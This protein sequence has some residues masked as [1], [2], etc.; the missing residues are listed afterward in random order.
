MTLGYIAKEKGCSISTIQRLF[1]SYLDNPSIPQI[2]TNNNCHLLIDGTYSS[3][4]CQLNYFDNDLKYLQYFDMV[5]HETYLD[6]RMGL[7]ALKK[8]GL[9]IVSITCDGHKGLLNAIYD[10]FP[11]IVV[12][13]CVVHIVRMSI[14]YLRQKP[15]YFA[16]I[17]LKKIVRELSYINSHDEK[18]LWIKSF[19]DWEQTY[20]HFLQEKTEHISG[21]KRYTHRLIRRTRSLIGHAIPS[22]FHYLDDPQIPKSNNGLEC[23]FSYLK[24]NLRIHRGLSKKHV[25]SFLSWYAYF[26]YRD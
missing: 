16:A 20:Y 8:A 2:K 25:K 6:Y 26:K 24:N 5:K 14:I 19:L 12:Q 3:D 4:W 13:R 15:R 1:K 11:G 18:E 21:R 10:V 17:E 9:K 22:M 7:E 23:R